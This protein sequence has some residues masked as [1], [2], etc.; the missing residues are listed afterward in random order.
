VGTPPISNNMK[1][2]MLIALVAILF[3]ACGDE[4]I[5]EQVA[6]NTYFNSFTI[7]YNDWDKT[8]DDTGLYF[9][10]KFHLDDLSKDSY[11]EVFDSGI[12]QAFLE[13]P[14]DGKVTDSP[15]PFTDFIYIR[16][17]YG[18]YEKWEEQFTVEFQPDGWVTFILKTDDHAD[19]YPFF[20]EYT[21]I[22]KFLW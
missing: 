22:L 4:Y 19:D 21:F 8:S 20:D 7:P 15:L 5:T 11:N 10:A 14:K 2:F 6:P 9:Y 13:Y 3:T 17:A 12:M 18:N 16:N 1:K